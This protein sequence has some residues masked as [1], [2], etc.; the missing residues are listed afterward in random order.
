MSVSMDHTVRIWS[1]LAPLTLDDPRLWAATG[2]CMPV[3][4]RIEL[5]G[6]FPEQAQRDRQRCLE[7][8]ERTRKQRFAGSPP[9]QAALAG[10]DAT[11]DPGPSSS[12]RP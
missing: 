9:G 6:V 1:D 3:E 8:V 7:R 5:L 12:R 10:R 11:P 2:Y 4:R